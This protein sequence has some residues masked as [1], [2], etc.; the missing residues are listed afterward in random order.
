MTEQLLA[1]VVAWMDTPMG[2]T[3]VG[4]IIVF[5][6]VSTIKWATTSV[7]ALFTGIP[8]R[9]ERWLNRQQNML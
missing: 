5:I 6:A 8:K 2:V 3:V 4:A 1:F 9:F 7:H